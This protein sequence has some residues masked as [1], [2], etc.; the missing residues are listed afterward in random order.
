MHVKEVAVDIFF[1]I[2]LF[3]YLEAKL[4]NFQVKS[5][6]KNWHNIYKDYIVLFLH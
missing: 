3:V 6:L 1:L 4:Y 5:I 2:A